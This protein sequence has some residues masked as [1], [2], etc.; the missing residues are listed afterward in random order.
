MIGVVVWSNA[1]REKS[2]IWCEDHGALAYL[3]GRENLGSGH[4]A[5]PEAGDLLELETEIIG[6]LRHA[7]AVAL[8]SERHCPQLPAVLLREAASGEPH[9]RLVASQDVSGHTVASGAAPVRI[10]AAC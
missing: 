9:L 7:R 6:P 3:Q 8:I 5:W 1:E 4:A 2:V 10:A